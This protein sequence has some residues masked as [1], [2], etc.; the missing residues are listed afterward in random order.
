MCCC[1][2]GQW[3]NGDKR[4]SCDICFLFLSGPGS[5]RLGID[6]DREAI[7]LTLQIAYS[8]VSAQERDTKPNGA[9]NQISAGQTCLTWGLRGAN[10]ASLL[11]EPRSKPT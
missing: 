5:K 6:G 1:I 11:E 9:E 3:K 2:S 8:K 4:P 10:A 7:P